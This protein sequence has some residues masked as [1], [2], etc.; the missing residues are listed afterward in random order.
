MELTH[1]FDGK[2]NLNKYWSQKITDEITTGLEGGILIDASSQE[3]GSMIDRSTLLSKS[4]KILTVDFTKN[5]KAA[6]SATKKQ[7]RGTFARFCCENNVE[8][9]EDVVKFNV[10][11][12][13]EGVEETEE[14]WVVR[15]EAEE[16]EKKG[17][18][19]K[20]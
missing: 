17:T 2:T 20:K 14:G 5:G 15:F 18:K 6:A 13:L 9:Y 4:I 12:R 11:Y 19:R 16:E 7:S 8:S 1:K 3:Y 10:G